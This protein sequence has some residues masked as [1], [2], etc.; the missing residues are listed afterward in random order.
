MQDQNTSQVKQQA[1][2]A[3]LLDLRINKIPFF[4]AAVSQSSKILATKLK[5]IAR[6]KR[7]NFQQS[8]QGSV[9]TSE[10]NQAKKQYILTQLDLEPMLI[11]AMDMEE[12]H[13][14]TFDFA[15]QVSKEYRRFLILCL[16]NQ[17]HPVVPSTHIDNFWHLHILDTQKYEEDC[18]HCFGYMLHHFPY[19]GMRG[20]QDAANLR[21]SW[22]ETLILYQ[23][24]FGEAAPENLWPHSNRCPNCGV[25]CK[26]SYDLDTANIFDG[27]RPRLADVK[28]NHVHV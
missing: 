24:T 5:F 16:E 22:L 21:K 26:S 17:N 28:F 4:N 19:F 13:G 23:F 11:K 3:A 15:C 25:R 18:N 12:G 8:N 1:G 6:Q 27:R 2:G 14:W 10:V 7:S 9:H 20:E